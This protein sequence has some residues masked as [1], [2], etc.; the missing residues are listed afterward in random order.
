MGRACDGS[1]FGIPLASGSGRLSSPHDIG[2]LIEILA[3][4]RSPE[5]GC[6]WDLAQTHATLAPY[7]I[8][9]A[10]ELADAIA[11]ASNVDLRDE[12]G[13]CLLQVVFHA[14]LA[15]EAGAFA[16]ADVVEAIC[17]KML[18]R[19]PHVFGV[20]ALVADRDGEGGDGAD[21]PGYDLARRRVVGG[22]RSP[23]AW[24]ALKAR[25]RK[26]RTGKWVERTQ[27][28]L[29]ELDEVEAEIG[30]DEAA[31][32]D[33]IGDLLFAVGN[34]A[35]HTRIDPEAALRSAN[36]K[37]ERR[38]A[39]IEHALASRGSSP[40]EASLAE[41]EALWREAKRAERPAANRGGDE[42]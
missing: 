13:D 11:R 21:L 15:E 39:F 26:H 42:R 41:M 40:G 9:E 32:L 29:E 25:E 23:T 27:I 37:F 38:F 16:F 34:L 1:G 20:H 17:S 3:A 33:E 8:E 36:A 19:H 35:R 6:P 7:A 31:L 22:E 30:N 5:T 18:R 28:L 14:R 4:L 12:L 2:R 24:E 10:Y